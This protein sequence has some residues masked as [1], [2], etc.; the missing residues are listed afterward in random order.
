MG[1]IWPLDRV[2]KTGSIDQAS[3]QKEVLNSPERNESVKRI[4]LAGQWK[5]EKE[6]YLSG[7]HKKDCYNIMSHEILDRAQS[8]CDL[9]KFSIKLALQRNRSKEIIAP[10][11]T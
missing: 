2:I 9:F 7:R 4:L 1:T 11:C 3:A 8:P 6:E 10:V 5:K